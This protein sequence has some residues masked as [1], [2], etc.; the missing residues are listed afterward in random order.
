M[1]WINIDF[2]KSWR[3][4]LEVIVRIVSLVSWSCTLGIYQLQSVRVPFSP[5]QVLVLITFICG[6]VAAAA[7]LGSYK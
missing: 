3:G 7:M 5:L 4:V 2:L 1:G 6:A